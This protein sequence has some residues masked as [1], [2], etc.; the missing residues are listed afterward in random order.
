M[1]TALN[2][3]HDGALGGTAAADALCAAQAKAAGYGGTFRAFLSSSTQNVK[4]LITGSAAAQPVLNTHGQELFPSW[5]AVFSTSTWASGSYLYAFDGKK[6]D[7]NTGA[8][9]PWYDARGWTG[10]TTT[11]LVSPNQTCQ[12]WTSAAGLGASGELDMRRLL[13]SYTNSC[14]QTLAVVCVRV[15]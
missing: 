5:T 11:G 3:A 2:N 15:K 12:D 4:D 6:V 7:E 8:A 13:F 1:L 9:P 10:S 14:N